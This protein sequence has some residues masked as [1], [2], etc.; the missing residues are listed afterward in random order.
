MAVDRGP[1]LIAGCWEEA[2]VPHYADL[3]MGLLLSPHDIMAG[4]FQR[5]QSKAE[6]GGSHT[7]FSDLISEAVYHQF[8]CI[9]FV[10]SES[11]D[12]AHTQGEGD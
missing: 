8:C 1:Q 7:I 5:Q 9:L 12:V 4:F 3:S 10:R 11:L 2:S 6:E